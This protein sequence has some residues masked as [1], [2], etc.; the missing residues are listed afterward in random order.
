MPFLE[1]IIV[2]L[3][4]ECIYK[5]WLL[6]AAKDSQ[7]VDVEKERHLRQEREEKSLAQVQYL[8]QHGEEEK[9]F[10]GFRTG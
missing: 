2:F 7:K 6:S 10:K 4:I 9:V 8:N 1:S 5:K 3:Q